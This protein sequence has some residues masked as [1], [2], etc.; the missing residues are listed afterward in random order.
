[1]FVS[2]DDLLWAEET[3]ARL[4]R[5]EPR[6]ETRNFTPQHGRREPEKL[7][8]GA[9]KKPFRGVPDKPFRGVPKRIDFNFTDDV[10]MA[11]S[12]QVA[13]MASTFADDAKATSASST[14]CKV[15]TPKCQAMNTIIPGAPRR[16]RG[17]VRRRR[18]N[19]QRRKTMLPRR[20][21]MLQPREN[22]AT[23]SRPRIATP[24]RLHT[25]GSSPCMPLQQRLL[26]LS[27]GAL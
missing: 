25:T 20:E 8:R 14:I 21:A 24:K 26:L 6:Q 22:A 7:F 17:G 10:E 12:E 4:N 16:L 27:R 15:E 13:S 18:N 9:P 1:M 11:T 5:S 23:P 19:M 2:Q 3:L